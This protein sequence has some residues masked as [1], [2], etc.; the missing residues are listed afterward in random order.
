MSTKTVQVCDKCQEEDENKLT[1][2]STTVAFSWRGDEHTVDL[3]ST[4]L[5]DWEEFADQA[6]NWA[7]IGSVASG[8]PPSKRSIDKKR[9]ENQAI[10]KW[11]NENGYELGDRGRIP[12]EVRDRW[13]VESN[14]PGGKP[15]SESDERLISPPIPNPPVIRENH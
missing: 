2:A 6:Q 14:L 8:P 1:L 15:L 3:C 9:E 7:E 10:R 13:R 11:A 12:D 5:A 4:H